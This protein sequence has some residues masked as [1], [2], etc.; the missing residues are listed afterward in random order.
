MPISCTD[1]ARFAAGRLPLDGAKAA[2]RPLDDARQLGMAE[3]VEENTANATS[4]VHP[5]NPNHS[6]TSIRDVAS[7]GELWLDRLPWASGAHQSADR[8]ALTNGQLA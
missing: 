7:I 2:P 5:H 1:P 3:I 4:K 6:V 8:V